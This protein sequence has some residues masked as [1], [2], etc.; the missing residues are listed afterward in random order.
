MCYATA[1][2]DIRNQQKSGKLP[3]P[4]GTD[5][6]GGG[7]T[8]V[9]LV[10]MEHSPTPIRG[11]AIPQA[12][13][14][15]YL[16][17]PK[18][19]VALLLTLLV[20]LL[21]L[22][23]QNEVEDQRATL[24]A[25]VLWLEQ[26]ARF[27]LDGN[28]DLLQQLALDL[29]L[30]DSNN[31]FF[32]T[33][34][35]HLL[36][37]SPTLTQIRWLDAR[38]RIVDALPAMAEAPAPVAGNPRAAEVA[39][40]ASERARKFGK[41]V[42]SDINR[43]S[44][45]ASFALHVPVAASG[46]PRGEIVAVYSLAAL[47]NHLTPWWLAQKYQVRIIDDND[48]GNTLATKS[49][50]DPGT[51]GDPLL[52][53]RLPFDPPGNGLYFQVTAYKI[54]N[55]I[56][57]TLIATLILILAGAI[58]LSLWL[59]RGLIQR[60]LTAEQA[61]RSEYAFRKAM[62]DS[63]TVGMR[64]RDRAGRITYVNPAFCRMVGYSAEELIGH[65]PPMPYWVPEDMEQTEAMHRAVLAGEAPGEGFELRFLRRNGE[66]FD[67]LVY[68]APLI[69][70]DGEHSGWM[71]SILDVSARKRVEE[72]ARQQHEK[73]QFTSRLVTMGE[74]AS[75][76]AHELN[77]PLAA[78]AS[79]NTGCLN[80]IDA[81]NCSAEDLREALGKLGAQAQRAGHI[82]R[83]VHDF[84]RKSEP[85][86][87]PCDLAEVIE[88]S[89]GLI[90]AVAKSRN[91]LIVREI[92]GMRPELMA[93]RVML[94]Q[95]LLNL[96]R[97]GIEAMEEAPP[98]HR[99]LTVTLARVDNQMQIRVTDRG[100]GIPADVQTRLFMPLFSTKP[101]GMGM[102]LNICRSI[103][104]FHHGRLWLEANPEGGSVFVINL[105]IHSATTP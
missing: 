14:S 46:H 95:V 60:R 1:I 52:S 6:A 29:A 56:A 75:T 57:Q 12:F 69:D 102:G 88:E 97:N 50:V 25:D 48:G 16:T 103:I 3:D 10:A 85:K 47:L 54:A 58:L 9:G 13:P 39:A 62:E 94:E 7:E 44:D 100:T 38:G 86:L 45:E 64:A 28:A 84:V 43:D 36:R 70:A 78:I 81:G 80:R 21:W 82:I 55:S 68:E 2:V 27:H 87:A 65:Q 53:Y 40:H 20:A 4:P 61:L 73:L 59:V 101:E 42:Y 66:R 32:R 89:I 22:L 98:A 96:M 63:L 74:M 8:Q 76:L 15:W 91:I 93:D 37:N 104:E 90:D 18:I 99:Q 79:Y 105:P 77:Q 72:T 83:R 67:A 34:A 23:R 51:P 5:D 92:P 49:R 17:I 33:R 71:A 26:N 19:A 31:E 35:R 41:S 30:D 24:I 11:K